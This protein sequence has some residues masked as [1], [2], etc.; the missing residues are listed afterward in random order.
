MKIEGVIFDVDGLLLDTESIYCEAVKNVTGK[1]LTPELNFQVLGVT[2]I[3]AARILVNGLKL[4]MTPEEYLLLVDKNLATIL[5]KCK[6]FPGAIE[7]VEKFKAKGIPMSL[8]TGSNRI[9]FDIKTKSH[10]EFFDQFSI[11]TSGDDVK[12]GKPNP[13][14]FLTSMKKMGLTD[15][16]KIVVF[17]DS[18][19]GIKAANSAGMIAVMVPDKMLPIKSAL[20]RFDA[21]PD[22]ILN[23][24]L[25]FD[26]DTTEI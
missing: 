1:E 4:N 26:P 22:L 5:P 21:K 13:E 19:A 10:Q 15:P 18:P 3:T 6:M 14:I 20:E 2:G 24:L 12:V 25:D 7:I 8:A 17:E 23:S 9:N 11:V 16:S